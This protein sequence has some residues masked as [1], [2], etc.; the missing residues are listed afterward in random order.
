MEREELEKRM[1]AACDDADALL[2]L[3]DILEACSEPWARSLRLR[4][5]ARRV[6]LRQSV[7]APTPP[8][9]PWLAD[10]GIEAPDGRPLYQYR[11]SKEQFAQIQERLRQR[12]PVLHVQRLRDDCALFVLWAAEWFRRCY[13]GDIQ[14]WSDL[15]N[16]IGLALDQAGWRAMADQGLRF[17]QIRPLTL[18]GMHLRLSAIARQ[19][20][21]PI[22]ALQ[23]KNAGWA[24]KYLER[25]TALLLAEAD[26]DLARAD[27]HASA[28]EA[29]VPPTWRHDGMRTVCAELA[30]QIVLLRREAEAGGAVSGS[31][32]SAWLDM[33]RP[34]WRERLPLVIED[35]GALIDGLM[36][37]VPLKG[38]SGSIRATRL[39]VRG[40]HGWR[41][42]A[43]LDLQ[44]VLR[45]VDG[46]AV[47][48]ALS[49]EWSRLRLYPAGEF[50]RHASG[51]L[52][53]VEPGE[54]GEWIAR[55][56]TART[57]FD[58]PASVPVEVELRGEGKRVCAPFAIP[59]GGRVTAGLRACVGDAADNSAP[60]R[61]SIVGTGSGSYRP[62]Q[63]YLD[64]P[65]GWNVESADK[66]ANAE[67]IETLPGQERSLW[68]VSGNVLVRSTHDDL[69]LV[70]CG[71]EAERRD[72]LTLVGDAPRGC[73]SA[74][75]RVPLF[76]GMPRLE[77]R[78][79]GRKRGP[80]VG[81]AWWRP[82]GAREWQPLSEPPSACLC[83]L[84]WLD[85]K[86]RHVRDRAEA[87]ILP[88][89]FAV[90]RAYVG[91][92][93]EYS[94]RGWP[95]RVEWS[96]AQ[97]S[98]TG[99]WR[100]P[101]RGGV[102]FA[103][104]VTL[105]GEHTPPISIRVPLPHQAWI[106]HWVDGPARRNTRLSIASLHQFVARSENLCELMADLLD[107]RGRPVAQGQASWWVEGELPL[108]AIRDDL[109]ALLRPFD[110]LRAEIRL[111]FNDG[112]ED[113]WYVREFDTALE[114]TGGRLVPKRALLEPS[115]VVGRPLHDPA[116]EHDEFPAYGDGIGGHRPIEL[117]RLKGEWLIYLRSDDRVISEPLRLVGDPLAIPPSTPLARAMAIPDRLARGAV[118]D[119]LCEA[120][121]AEPRAPV[122][123]ETIQAI[124]RLA[125][126]LDGLRA[127][128]FDILAKTTKYPALGPLLLFNAAPSELDAVLQLA[129]GLPL[130]WATIPHRH[131]HSASAAKFEDLYALMPDRIADIAKVISERRLAIAERDD[132]LGPLL[133]LPPSRQ[134]LREIA[135][136]FLNRSADRGSS[137]L[138]N[139]FRPEH[140]T[141]LPSWPF[142]DSYWRALD[143]PIA[144]ARAAA[145][146]CTLSLPQLYCIKDVARRHP[147][148]FREAFAAALSEI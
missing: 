50:A 128:T 59:H 87:L 134:P 109:A 7:A 147:R 16:E 31:L 6:Q 108:S 103:N 148:Y 71:Q 99:A 35:G 126:S 124:I 25:L 135:Q 97:R 46:H 23:G 61:L 17:W 105:I 107:E 8:V 95:G 34:N 15:G 58:L 112:N 106:S 129:G 63:L 21:F 29:M 5:M 44:G 101:R 3:C 92:W 111:N 90:E 137:T 10:L 104:D 118:L 2:H 64:L 127:G 53:V 110:D 141:R 98:S 145:E 48:S 19:G 120:V 47:L 80:N 52:A 41:E 45:D 37:T 123:H 38:G 55:P 1:E 140:A 12:A 115:R 74:D 138:A 62:D 33:H 139:P 70:R 60:D 40:G 130:V 85:A 94:V 76:A 18:N 26:P 117:P 102:E 79:S 81:E 100:L 75:A 54:D 28:H 91:D 67:E 121:I 36:R 4:A 114:M 143:A 51:E 116:R 144:T 88:A 14:R 113:Y 96:G 49:E 131:W 86:T 77:L 119:E 69:Y 93:V 142:S 30:L 24:E 78:D 82:T 89:D 57:D 84:A 43:Q 39:L 42:R 136:A 73:V 146:Q 83:E 72:A 27:A 22:A 66:E 68:Q 125:A 20:G 11:V 32:V 132:V 122:H 65:I 133:E 56:T 13:S 9:L